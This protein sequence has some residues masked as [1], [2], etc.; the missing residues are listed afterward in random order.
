MEQA[1]AVHLPSQ[2]GK[3]MSVV[4]AKESLKEE[5]ERLQGHLSTLQAHLSAM[6]SRIREI[7]LELEGGEE[8]GVKGENKK[9]GVTSPLSHLYEALDRLSKLKRRL[10]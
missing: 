7:D 4:P 9:T 8:G 5:R 10:W 6:Q 1:T 3:D 2:E